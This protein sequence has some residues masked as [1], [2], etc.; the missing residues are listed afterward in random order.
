MRFITYDF[1]F[2]ARSQAGM[3]THVLFAARWRVGRVQTHFTQSA[4]W[5]ENA[6][7]T[8]LNSH[9]SLNGLD[10]QYSLSEL[11]SFSHFS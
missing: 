3:Q 7:L 1:I 11:I 6:V 4:M 2:L 5:H 10:P 9:A 8:L